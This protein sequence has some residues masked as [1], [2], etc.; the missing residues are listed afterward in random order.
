MRATSTSDPSYRAI[1]FP[2]PR[3]SASPIVF[4]SVLAS[5]ASVFG[6]LFLMPRAHPTFHQRGVHTV[7][8]KKLARTT[9]HNLQ[10]LNRLPAA[11]TALRSLNSD[12]IVL[13]EC[14]S[15]NQEKMNSQDG[16]AETHMP[17][18]TRKA[19]QSKVIVALKDFMNAQYY[20][21][22]ALGT[23]PQPF[24]VVFDTGSGN[25]WVPSSR[26]KGF[27][28]ACLLHRRYSSEQSSTYTKVGKPFSIRYGSGSMSG[29]TSM[30]RRRGSACTK[31][32]LNTR[33]FICSRRDPIPQ[34]TLTIGGLKLPNVTFAEA[35][36]E[37]GVSFAMTKFDGI[38]G[39]GFGRHSSRLI[40]LRAM[41]HLTSPHP[42][43]LVRR[44]H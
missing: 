26:C 1:G 30:V 44:G 43:A 35:T 7:R 28:I 33:K 39:L 34:D 22:V 12:H 36:S 13:D 11:T 2:Q 37:P 38:I 6:V 19:E 42:D 15:K 3:F 20:G 32:L 17:V 9:W 23:P 31:A 40:P 10:E 14:L 5:L 8:L 25:L 29:F 4:V 41:P 18:H 16:T 27:N 24:T 21:V